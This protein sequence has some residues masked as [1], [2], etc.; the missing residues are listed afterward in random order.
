MESMHTLFLLIPIPCGGIGGIILTTV[1]GIHITI[2]GIMI[3]Y[4]TGGHLTI[5]TTI[6][7]GSTHTQAIG[8]GGISI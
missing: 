5:T 7:L 4:G 8:E 1:G 2:H 6:M 3:R